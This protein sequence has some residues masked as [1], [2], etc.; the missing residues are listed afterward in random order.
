MSD[1]APFIAI[2]NDYA[3]QRRVVWYREY[4]HIHDQ[5]RGIRHQ[6]RVDPAGG[7]RVGRPPVWSV[8]PRGSPFGGAT[9]V[10]SR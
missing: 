6:H 5:V 10:A 9:T 3:I 7:L 8:P 4:L 1:T 2:L